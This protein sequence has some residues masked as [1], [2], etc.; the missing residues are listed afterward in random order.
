MGFLVFVGMIIGACIVGKK[1]YEDKQYKD[2]IADAEWRERMR[3]QSLENETIQY[4]QQKQKI[5]DDEYREAVVIADKFR[6]EAE[7][8]IFEEKCLKSSSNITL[9]CKTFFDF[10]IDNINGIEFYNKKW[11]DE[12]DCLIKDINDEEYIK[13]HAEIKEYA[14]H[15]IEKD[16]ISN[17]KET[18]FGENMIGKGLDISV[19]YGKLYMIIGATNTDK[20][21]K[22]LS[23]LNE[24]LDVIFS[25]GLVFINQLEYGKFEL[26]LDDEMIYIQ[27]HEKEIK[28]EIQEN[29]LHVTDN[30]NGDF[31]G[32]LRVFNLDFLKKMAMLMWYYA[33][34]KPFDSDDFY[35]ACGF[36]DEF[37]ATV[38]P[39]S[40]RIIA[41]IYAK[42]QMG[43][44]EL[45]R[46][47]IDK[48]NQAILEGR[49]LYK[50]YIVS[51]LAWMELY[52]LELN[53]LKNIISAKGT[54][55]ESMQERLSF[56]SD[57]GTTNIK[58]YDI[59]PVNEL[60]YYDSSSYAW[61]SKEY[62]IFF[63]KISMK[64]ILLEY[65]L[66][67]NIWRKTIPLMSGQKFNNND[68]Y[69]EFK[70]M[71]LDFDGEVTCRKIKAKAV[72][73]ENMIY[74]EAILFEFGSERN[75]CMSMLFSCEK[76]GRNLNLV[77]ITMFTPEND[78]IPEDMKKYALAIQKN[79]YVESFRE[80]ILQSIDEVLK[81][82][83]QV[84]ED[85]S[86]TYDKKIFE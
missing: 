11:R 60:L 69:E 21:D 2:A 37:T 34:K 36:F 46:Q 45:V 65:S 64:N 7:L 71:I 74:D 54:I 15:M 86:G 39:I 27:Q 31:I 70:K 57:G 9:D 85:E 51:A 42:N 78:L 19:I 32:M 49:A 83:K 62:D 8:V 48:F 72:D 63:K 5:I 79:I 68:I 76:F 20:Y 14:I 66:S 43:G 47:D 77:I 75:R 22:L 40:E 53:V 17:L 6:K 41:E 73:L 55:T 26:P 4:E 81:E 29:L 13:L 28:Q 44:L 18:E 56:L 3:Q 12:Y 52:D 23:N 67:V 30:E 61:T 16:I 50:K 1:I 82:K 58:I 10:E 33:K 80:S 24:Y 38:H 59:N 35:E 25:K 84:Y